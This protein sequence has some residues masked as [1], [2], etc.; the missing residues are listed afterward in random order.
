MFS[1]APPRHALNRHLAGS[2]DI[3]QC[4]AAIT[5]KASTRWYA[6]RMEQEKRFAVIQVPDLNWPPA[7]EIP[8]KRFR[9]FVAANITDVSTQ[10]VSDFALTALSQG[11]V[12]L[13]SWGPDCERFHDIVDEVLVEDDIGEQKFAGPNTSD[14][15]ITTW[16]AK[17]S[18]EDAIDFFATSAVPTDGFAADSDFRLVICVANQQ[19]AAQANQY[20]Q[21]AK[22]F[23]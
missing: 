21:S 8:S 10:T 3:P 20:L 9:L 22:F 7:L 16:H 17:D 5:G 19:W 14:V 4:L 11:M 13:C 23:V 15:V 18:L 1:V 2:A 12:Y 6:E